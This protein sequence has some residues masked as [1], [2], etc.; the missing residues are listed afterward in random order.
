[1]PA[2]WLCGHHF[3]GGSIGSDLNLLLSR[4]F[5]PSP[6]L[7]R[8][9]STSPVVLWF[10]TQEGALDGEGHGCWPV[11]SV[12]AGARWLLPRSVRPWWGLSETRPTGGR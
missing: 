4:K 3:L 9:P 5:C 10:L 11:A 7:R 1:M 6:A 8:V 12:V 2:W